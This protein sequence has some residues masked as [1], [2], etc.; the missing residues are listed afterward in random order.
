M[1]KNTGGRDAIAVV[2]FSNSVVMERMQTSKPSTISSL[3]STSQ[4]TRLKFCHLLKTCAGPLGKFHIL[5]NGCGGHVTLTSSCSRLLSALSLSQPELRLIVSSVQS[6]LKQFYDCGLFM[7]CNTLQLIHTSTELDIHF[8]TL[9]SLY[10]LFLKKLVDLIIGPNSSICLKADFTNLSVIIAYVRS[11]ILSKSLATLTEFNCDQ[12]SQ[13]IV[14]AFLES[15]PETS[16]V[17]NNGLSDGIFIVGLDKQHIKDS[18][19]HHGVLLEYPEILPMQGIVSLNIKTAKELHNNDCGKE[20]FVNSCVRVAL[21]TCSLSGDLDEV[22]DAVFEITQRQCEDVQNIILCK[23]IE[24]CNELDQLNVGLL[25]CQKVIHPNVKTMLTSKGILFVERIGSQMIPYLQDITGAEP[26]T[27]FVIKSN[28]I[29][30]LGQLTAVE[31]IVLADKSFLFLKRN[32]S[33]VVTLVVCEQWGERLAE[34]KNC[35]TVAIHG[36]K[37]LIKEQRLL[38]GGGC[39]QIYCS[40]QLRYKMIMEL[41]EISKQLNCSE[42]HILSSLNT[43]LSSLHHWVYSIHPNCETLLVD[44][45]SYHCWNSDE[46]LY[47]PF[48]SDYTVCCCGMKSVSKCDLEHFYVIARNENVSWQSFQMVKNVVIEDNPLQSNLILDNYLASKEALIR[49]IFTANLVLS[50]DKYI[51]DSN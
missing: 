22:V 31:H 41:K 37:S 11:I 2:M 35:V 32:L 6:H 27:S 13:L 33:P 49:S 15:I 43:F 34:L 45:V 51:V 10:G 50:I 4:Q 3:T 20:T 30:K 1:L 19:L 5:R 24:L 38:P 39:W 8:S 21:I 47:S 46:T 48:G 16:S 18:H 40:Y 7:A 28:I 25:L 26:L 9:N 14:R 12:M 17:R 42:S 36:L 23:M 29:D 44:P